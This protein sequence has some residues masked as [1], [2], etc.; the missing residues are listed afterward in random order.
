M[1]KVGG[2]FC[3]LL[4]ATG[5][6]AQ[7]PLSGPELEKIKE[8]LE[9]HRNGEQASGVK[10]LQRGQSSSKYDGMTLQ[11]MEQI[12]PSSPNPYVSFLPV[13]VTPDYEYWDAYLAL[14]A[15][16]RALQQRVRPPASTASLDPLPF[17]VFEESEPNNNISN[18]TVVN[19]G[20]LPV[21]SVFTVAGSSQI[22]DI[23]FFAVRLIAG[24]VLSVAADELPVDNS[25]SLGLIELSLL[26][27]N[28]R[29]L[30][31]PDVFANAAL[32]PEAS[33]L[34]VGG[35]ARINFVISQSGEYFLRLRAQASIDYDL[36]I[37]R[38]RPVLESPTAPQP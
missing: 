34:L 36:R 27:A 29:L 1:N 13:G 31:A 23:D 15:E 16:R 9:T 19:N 26:D 33:P 25:V 8:Q 12:K 38:F 30:V 3:A 32:F 37:G 24:D 14:K 2:I 22:G 7:G 17:V 20:R 5:A 18:A 21:N 4:F 11:E 10:L 35:D 6:Q 28:G